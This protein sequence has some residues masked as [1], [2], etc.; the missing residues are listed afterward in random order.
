MWLCGY[1]AVWCKLCGCVWCAVLCRELRVAC[2]EFRA[3]CCVMCVMCCVV[4]GSLCSRCR[5]AGAL[6]RHSMSR[7]DMGRWCAAWYWKSMEKPAKD[8]MMKSIM[9][10]SGTVRAMHAV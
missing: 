7:R 2:C 3:A 9:G 8:G 1:V 6:V 10:A 5:P 4:A